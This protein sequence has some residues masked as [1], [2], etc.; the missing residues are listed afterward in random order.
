MPG[1]FASQPADLL[2][3]SP[4]GLVKVLLVKILLAI[5]VDVPAS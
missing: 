5:K 4:V 1:S 2:L 3:L